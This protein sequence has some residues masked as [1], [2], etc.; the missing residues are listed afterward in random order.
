MV[1]RTKGS[2]CHPEMIASWKRGG[3]NVLDIHISDLITGKIKTLDNIRVLSAPGGFADGD[4]LGAAM[5]WAYMTMHNQAVADLIIPFMQ[6]PDTLS[7]GICNGAQWGLRCGW[8]PYPD[9]PADQRPS[10]TL[11]ES[12]SFTH[13]WILLKILESPSILYQGM[14]GSILG[15]YVA[16]GEG[17]FNCDHNP[18]LIDRVLEDKQVPLVY[19]DSLGRRTKAPPYSP[20]GEFIAAVCDP[21]G[22]HTY[23]MPHTFDRADL[24]RLWEYFPPEW[25]EENLIPRD[26]NDLEVAP[27]HQPIINVREWCDNN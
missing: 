3:F 18:G 11:N 25:L 9:L 15:A 8:A 2:T 17:R 23:G 27:W 13:R 16:N 4:T 22:R 1:L 10:F 12:N 7:S 6:R 19:V 21:T 24:L 20:S 14:E 5:I 26:I